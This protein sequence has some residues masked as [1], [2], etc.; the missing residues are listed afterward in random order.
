MSRNIIFVDSG[1]DANKSQG[2]IVRN[3]HLWKRIFEELAFLSESG[4]TA[5]QE[6]SVDYFVQYKG[7]KE[8]K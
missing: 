1:N 8:E 4:V 2:F 3:D 5:K 6:K 7:D